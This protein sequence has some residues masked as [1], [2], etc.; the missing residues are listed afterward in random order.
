MRKTSSE[1]NKEWRA[2]HPEATRNSNVK[3]WAKRYGITVE[4]LIKLQ[5]GPCEICGTTVSGGRHGRFHVDHCHKNNVVRGSLCH[6]CNILV[7]A[8]EKIVD[9]KL[10]DKIMG[11]LIK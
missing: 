8:I 1:Y 2:K 11:Y 5:Q 10:F 3:I 4:Q 9:T 7:G 6:S